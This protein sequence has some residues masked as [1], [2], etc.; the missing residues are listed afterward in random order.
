VDGQIGLEQTP[1]LYIEKLQEVF[2]EVKRVLKPHGTLWVN[3]GDSYAGSGRG[4]GSINKKGLPPKTVFVGDN[5]E[6]PYKIEGYK[7][8]DLMGIPWVLAFTLRQS[9]W[10][11]RQDIIW[12][13]PNPMPESV[14]DRCTKSHE[15]IFLLS[16]NKK[17]FFDHKSIMEK[18]VY[19]GRK[20]LMH[21]GSQKYSQPNTT[22]SIAK[23]LS[24]RERKRWRCDEHG[25]FVRN[26]RSVWTVSTQPE[27]ESHFACFP[28]NLIA[29]CVKAGCPE[30]GIVLDPF[31]GSG[32]TAVVARKLGRNYIGIEINPDYI[33]IANRKIKRELE[34]HTQ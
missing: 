8:K 30:N 27:R 26:K 25:N 20:D 11:L 33:E 4:K 23:S 34:R 10:F 14:R 13:K 21:K 15:Y 32:T 19:D 12:A 29:D 2:S 1:T 16:K 9:G 7:N 5:F 6:K 17:Y 3:I 22:G 31:M 18:A 24:T 28:Q